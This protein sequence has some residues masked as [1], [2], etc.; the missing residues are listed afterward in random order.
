MKKAAE[1]IILLSQLSDVNAFLNVIQKSNEIHQDEKE[2]LR[3]AHQQLTAVFVA[4]RSAC[5]KEF[6]NKGAKNPFDEEINFTDDLSKLVKSSREALEKLKHIPSLKEYIINLSN[7][8]KLFFEFLETEKRF[9][10][11]CHKI[12]PQLAQMIYLAIHVHY[13]GQAVVLGRAKQLRP[14]LDKYREIKNHLDIDINTAMNFASDPFSAVSFLHKKLVYL[15][16]HDYDK[17]EELSLNYDRL[18]VLAAEAARHLADDNLKQSVQPL[19]SILAEPFQRTGRYA[20]FFNGLFKDDQL[21]KLA[22]FYQKHQA[23]HQIELRRAIVEIKKTAAQMSES[24]ENLNKKLKYSQDNKVKLERDE[25]RKHFLAIRAEL[26]KK[27][28]ASTPRGDMGLLTQWTSKVNSALYNAAAEGDIEKAL[29]ALDDKELDINDRN[30]GTKTGN[31]TALMI[32][33]HNGHERLVS[34][35]LSLDL[36]RHP[37]DTRAQSGRAAVPHYTALHYA[38]RKGYNEI[39]RMLALVDPDCAMIA[40]KKNVDAP[41]PLHCA[42]AGKQTKTAIILLEECGTQQIF[43]K[44]AKGLNALQLAYDAGLQPVVTKMLS[45]LLKNP[46]QYQAELTNFQK[47]ISKNKAL[48]GKYLGLLYH[49]VTKD[50]AD[51]LDAAERGQTEKVMELHKKGVSLNCFDASE[52][53]PG[54]TPLMIACQHGHE[55]LVGELLR[56][57]GLKSSTPSAL[58]FGPLHFAVRGQHHRIIENITASDCSN[59]FLQDDQDGFIPLHS[60]IKLGANEK[61][62][63]ALL[64]H[65][66]MVQLK[67]TAKD[68]VT[69]PFRLAC[70]EGHT[71]IAKILFDEIMKSKNGNLIKQTI[72]YC[73]L[74]KKFTQFAANGNGVAS[75]ALLSKLD[76]ASNA[77]LILL[78][79]MIK[80]IKKSEKDSIYSEFEHNLKIVF[81]DKG[82]IY[83]GLVEYNTQQPLP[84]GF[85]GVSQREKVTIGGELIRICV[86]GSCDT[87]LDQSTWDKS[88]WI[89]ADGFAENLFKAVQMPDNLEIKKA[90]QPSAAFFQPGVIS[91]LKNIDSLIDAIVDEHFNNQNVVSSPKITAP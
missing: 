62:I 15:A 18:Y 14:I 17:L 3:E 25:Q 12:T 5:E 4:L 70:M 51:L 21:P 83:D 29:V 91:D 9:V 77:E 73:Y 72:A 58:G 48:A 44:N 86:I 35:L 45:I 90:G 54:M 24:T 30:V 84:I 85:D 67:Q 80:Y 56:V 46:E 34:V 61:T 28:K 49:T 11:R 79:D 63:A 8:R 33:S 27:R 59:L 47:Y 23:E 53:Y 75:K 69:T 32:A 22:E 68:G 57:K 64:K 19:V 13:R 26:P 1:L 55:I 74:R 66:P 42:I 52:I 65:M 31:F 16:E 20:L 76:K 37:I 71:K 82:L 60:A 40:S 7:Y 43:V 81:E 78:Y 88:T 10:D 2:R 41:L 89:K 50:E 38:A 39:V 36:T 6:A 87:Q